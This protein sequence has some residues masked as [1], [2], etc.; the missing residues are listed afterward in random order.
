[1][2]FSDNSIR[3][4]VKF[5]FGNNI[6][7]I[8]FGP[9]DASKYTPNKNEMSESWTDLKSGCEVDNNFCEHFTYK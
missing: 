7:D 6:L 5:C 3:L 8:F 1:M 9:M 4:S 2:N